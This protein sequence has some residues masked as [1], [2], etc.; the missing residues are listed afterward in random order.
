MFIS[1]IK[2]RYTTYKTKE[3]ANNLNRFKE[4]RAFN[5]SQNE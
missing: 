5:S 4:E 3:S 2:L 1:R